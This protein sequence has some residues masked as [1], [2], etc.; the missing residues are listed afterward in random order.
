VSDP[1]RPWP[2]LAE[3]GKYHPV[4][5]LQHLLCGHG[6][7]VAVDGVFGPG[8]AAAVHDFQ[9]RGRLPGDGVVG[10]RTWSALIVTVAS[11]SAGDAVCGV[12]EEFQ[13]RNLSGD[14]RQGVQIDGVF[15]PQTE[16]AVV[17]FQQ[18]LG[19]DIDGI[20]GPITWR[21]LISGMLSF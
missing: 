19:L 17:D 14:P 10:A 13:F 11:G 16:D 9:Q 5:T 21:A 6:L 8:T 12:Q 3:G 15:G 1:V 7:T 20:V 4:E 2:V 18:A